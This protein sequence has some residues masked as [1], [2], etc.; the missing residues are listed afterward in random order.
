MIGGIRAEMG[1]LVRI[2]E[3]LPIKSL[4]H[5][6]KLNDRLDAYGARA[7][8]NHRDH[9]AQAGSGGHQTLF[10]KFVD[11]GKNQD[12]SIPAIGAEAGNLIVATPQRSP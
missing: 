6:L 7:I 9:I 1:P 2:A 4:Q 11:T 12:L 8:E 5:V 3:V 10:S